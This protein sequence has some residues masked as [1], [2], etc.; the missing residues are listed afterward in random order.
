MQVF[1]VMIIAMSAWCFFLI[2]IFCEMI[3]QTI[4]LKWYHSYIKNTQTLP[5]Y[6]VRFILNF[7]FT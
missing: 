2:K 7:M 4:F 5:V 3:S 1:F 6:S